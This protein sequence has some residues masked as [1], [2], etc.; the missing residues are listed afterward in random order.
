MVVSHA[1]TQEGNVSRRHMSLNIREQIHR[2]IRQAK[3]H[4]EKSGT[5]AEDRQGD[6]NRG[7]ADR[8]IFHSHATN[9]VPKIGELRHRRGLGPLSVKTASTSRPGFTRAPA[10]SPSSSPSLSPPTD[11]M[12]M[13]SLQMRKAY[14]EQQIR[15]LEMK[16][17]DSG[18]KSRVQVADEKG[19]PIERVQMRRRSW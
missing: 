12:G 10:P 2:N 16:M 8:T 1:N 11:D 7:G 9:P 3:Q 13:Y 4:N 17:V 18:N 19:L 14:L 6:T 15:D 5:R